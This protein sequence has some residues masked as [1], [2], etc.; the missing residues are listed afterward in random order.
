V[1]QDAYRVIRGLEEYDLD[2]I[3]GGVGYDT[4]SLLVFF[5]GNGKERRFEFVNTISICN[6]DLSSE[7]F[8]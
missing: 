7:S 4:L 6:D 1:G 8:M 3:S 5:K 2:W